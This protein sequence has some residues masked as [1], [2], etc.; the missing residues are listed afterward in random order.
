MVT[1]LVSVAVSYI[2]CD[3]TRGLMYNNNNIIINMAQG[4]DRRGHAAPVSQGQACSEGA[5]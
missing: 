2:S 5:G 1:K 3:G 4:E